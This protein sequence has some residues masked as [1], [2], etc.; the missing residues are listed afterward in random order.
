MT[1]HLIARHTV[2]GLAVLALTAA[3][4]VAENKNSEFHWVDDSTKGTADL[5]FGKQPVLRYMYAYVT[6]SKERTH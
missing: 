3:S 5:M 4:T 2:F 6:S 1:R